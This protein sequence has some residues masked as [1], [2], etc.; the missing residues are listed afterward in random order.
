M[1]INFNA[2]KPTPTYSYG[3][4]RYGIPMTMSAI[5]C[6]ILALAFHYAC[7]SAE[8]STSARPAN[9]QRLGF[10]HA[11]IDA[12]NPLDLL[13][14]IGRAGLLLLGTDGQS[15][16]GCD[17]A[18]YQLDLSRGPSPVRAPPPAYGPMGHNVGDDAQMPEMQ[19]GNWLSPGMDMEARAYQVPS[20][21]SGSPSPRRGGLVPDVEAGVYQSRSPSPRRGRGGRRGGGRRHHCPLDMVLGL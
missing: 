2:I 6:V 11:I 5:E 15:K 3:D 7:S 14:G 8:Y 13:R 4:L 20:S 19:Q 9:V 17:A 16:G 1:L 12:L 10:F 21:R 18:R